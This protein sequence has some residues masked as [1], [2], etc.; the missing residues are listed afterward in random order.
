MEVKK[1]EAVYDRQA[2]EDVR[3]QAE[4][5]ARSQNHKKA[6]EY[7]NEALKINPNA[8][9][10]DYI[11]LA[12]V[13][14]AGKKT[15]QKA[16]DTLLKANKLYPENTVIVTNIFAFANLAKDW[17]S[18]IYCL[19]KLAQPMPRACVYLAIA[20]AEKGEKRKAHNT[21]QE[22]LKQFPNHPAILPYATKYKPQ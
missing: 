8:P 11:S 17:N 7:Y 15:K 18:S 14:F 2:Y 16:Y 4:L 22:G 10:D 12:K 21:I 1:S 3:N 13:Y 6:I 20:Y 5:C 19:T 9:V